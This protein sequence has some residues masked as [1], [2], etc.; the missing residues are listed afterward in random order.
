MKIAV[1][2]KSSRILGREGA[3][4]QIKS[5]N[6]G[7]LGVLRSWGVS[8]IHKGEFKPFTLDVVLKD[9]DKKDSCEN[10]SEAHGK[11]NP[12]FLPA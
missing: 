7:A 6:R 3:L 5:L 4:S 12:L 11:S 10:H 9:G 1:S 8:E 2:L